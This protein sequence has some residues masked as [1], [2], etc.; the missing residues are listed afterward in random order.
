MA[1]VCC[2]TSCTSCLWAISAEGNT[3]GIFKTSS[4]LTSHLPLLCQ[5][6]PEADRRAEADQG[7][8]NRP[9][10][11]FSTASS[12]TDTEPCSRSADL[13]VHTCCSQWQPQLRMCMLALS[14][15]SVSSS[16]YLL[17]ICPGA[18]YPGSPARPA[19]EQS[20]QGRSLNFAAS[21]AQPLQLQA[22]TSDRGSWK[23]QC[24][25]KQRQQQLTAAASNSS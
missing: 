25:Q 17:L 19:H 5:Q 12:P 1:L 9:S 13:I 10:V 16:L 14:S 2:S 4:L 8:H 22:L 24:S 18:H 6:P 20:A 7:Q 21:K 3:T 11:T 23:Q 15:V